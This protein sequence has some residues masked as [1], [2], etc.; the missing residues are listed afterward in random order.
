MADHADHHLAAVDKVPEDKENVD[1]LLT[2]REVAENAVLRSTVE[3]EAG[4]AVLRSTALE[5]AGNAVLHLVAPVHN[6]IAIIW[7][8]N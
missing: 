7:L 5:V 6:Y 2:V 8:W 3:V 4:N 1:H